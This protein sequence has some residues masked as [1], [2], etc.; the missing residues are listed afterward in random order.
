MSLLYEYMTESELAFAKE[1]AIFENESIHIDNSLTVLC[2]EH[3]TRL[4]DIELEAFL[5]GYTESEL[6][7]MYD[8]E[9]ILFTEGVK[10]IW[11][12]FKKW[13]KGIIDTL[14]G[15]AKDV[16][17]EVKEEAKKSNDEVELPANPNKAITFAKNTA[18]KIKNLVKFRNDDGTYNKTGIA[19][20]LAGAAIAGG[21]SIK[22]VSDIVSAIKTKTK[23]KKSEIPGLIDETVEVGKEL[24]DSVDSISNTSDSSLLNTIKEFV[25]PALNLITSITESLKNA[26]K[27]AGEK[28]KD[29]VEAVKSSVKNTI[30]KKDEQTVSPSDE[31]FKKRKK[32]VKQS[33]IKA[34]KSM[35]VFDRSKGNKINVT[36]MEKI[37]S[38]LK[39]KISKGKMKE[40][41]DDVKEFEEVIKLMKKNH[42][43]EFT[44]DDPSEHQLYDE[45]F[46][47][48][49]KTIENESEFD[50]ESFLESDNSE[51]LDELDL[52][53]DVL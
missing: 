50:F 21:V 11:E 17:S 22:G 15:K 12:N 49:V 45:L 10:E 32:E 3:E 23:I 1:N 47:E 14:L 35:N 5:N 2:M 33:L 48:S 34:A 28:V 25:S 39:S 41:E 8:K 26:L 46:E 13:I 36:D 18:S 38:E 44:F 19:I 6:T 52:L 16:P 53:V 7:D 51:T 43:M 9:M 29:G 37:V 24:K 30:G 31:E 20:D 27:V 4:N 42:V 40:Y